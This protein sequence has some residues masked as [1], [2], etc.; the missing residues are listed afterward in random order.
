VRAVLEQI[1]ADETR[2]AELAWR[3]VRWALEREPSL[4][5]VVEREFEKQFATVSMW[6][7]E[8]EGALDLERHG[9]LSS[10]TRRA[11]RRAVLEGVVRP[12]AQA[13]LGRSLRRGRVSAAKLPRVTEAY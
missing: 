9:V 6:G 13:L 4:V 2:H 12:A 11:L 5:G 3:F 7:E 1:S 10:R 8:P